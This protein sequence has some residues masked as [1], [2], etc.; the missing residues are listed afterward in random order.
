MTKLEQAIHAAIPPFT[1]S[2]IVAP[3]AQP[4]DTFLLANRTYGWYY[5]VGAV[6]SAGRILETGVKYGYSAIAMCKGACIS[7]GEF[8]YFVGID[9][10]ADGIV[11][12]PIATAAFGE[13]GIQHR[14]IREN[15]RHLK[16]DR[17][18]LGVSFDIVHV[19]ADHSPE[20][21][22]QELMLAELFVRPDGLILVDDVDAPHIDLAARNFARSVG[23]EPFLLPT[24]HG[25]LVI[26]MGKKDTL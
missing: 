21:I 7:V 17:D 5:A 20:G 8:P 2:E 6:K 14:I 10:E 12:N 18:S 19:D 16:M 26:P 1:D 9:A 3:A 22:A 23:C 13:L 11:C 4:E 25:L 15:T 24:Q